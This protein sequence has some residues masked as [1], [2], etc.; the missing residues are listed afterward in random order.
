MINDAGRALWNVA[1]RE[2]STATDGDQLRPDDPQV[3]REAIKLMEYVREMAL[4]NK[5]DVLDFGSFEACWWLTDLPPEVTFRDTPGRAHS[6][7][8]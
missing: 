5:S 6:A 3:H 1:R 8:T 4:A 2:G 7:R